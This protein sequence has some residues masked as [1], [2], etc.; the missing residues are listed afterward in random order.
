MV[1]KQSPPRADRELVQ[2]VDAALAENAIKSGVFLACRPGCSQCCIGVFEI[3]QLDA[4]RLR[5]G[6]AEL[7]RTDPKRAKKV[8]LRA[9]N[10]MQRLTPGFPG[11]KKTGILASGNE[12][13]EAFAQFGNDEPC[14][15]LDPEARTC[16]LYSHRPMTCRV[17]GPPV[18]SGPEGGLGVCELC[19]HGA[20]DNEIA[21]C[22]L[23]A[24]PHDFES[25][26]TKQYEKSCGRR[27][28]T[29]VAWCLAE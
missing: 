29:I 5:Q 12:A 7:D 27:G 20:T 15:A 17:F 24:D 13:E 3:S 18:R 2:I 19:F 26:V 14:P 28:K 23:N 11:S 16:D 9:K 22:E 8:R 25:K 10:S 6:L 4:A 1:A 21:A